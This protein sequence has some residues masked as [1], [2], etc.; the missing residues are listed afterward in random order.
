[1]GD[2]PMSLVP[3]EKSEK[4]VKVSRE[5]SP[6]IGISPNPQPSQRQRTDP[7][8]TRPIG[9]GTPKVSSKSVSLEPVD[10]MVVNTTAPMS[11][12]SD[13]PTKEGN[14][15]SGSDVPATILPGRD[16]SE[17]AVPVPISIVP[18]TPEVTMDPLEPEPEEVEM[19]EDKLQGEF[20][21]PLKDEDHTPPEDE[22]TVKKGGIE[23]DKI[24][25]NK[26]FIEHYLH[27]PYDTKSMGLTGG[28]YMD[29]ISEKFGLKKF[30]SD[31]KID[32]PDF[33]QP[34]KTSL[35]CKKANMVVN[36]E[37]LSYED[38]ERARP[39]RR[40][41]E[42]TQC[43]MTGLPINNGDGRPADGY[44]CEHYLIIGDIG[45][46]LRLALDE[47]ENILKKMVDKKKFTEFQELSKSLWSEVY[48]PSQP[49]SN[50]LKA[51]HDF[52]NLDHKDLS[53][54]VN[55]HNI[56]RMMTTLVFGYRN[57]NSHS[58]NFR[59]KFLAHI[60]GDGD[61][62]ELT[63]ADKLKREEAY[64]HS[65]IQFLFKQAEDFCELWKE[66][67][68]E[69][70]KMLINS[71]AS[72]LT[73]IR[74]L[75]MKKKEQLIKIGSKKP[76]S[77]AMKSITSFLKMKI[78]ENSANFL[79]KSLAKAM[80]VFDNFEKAAKKILEEGNVKISGSMK[81]GAKKI[82]D[83]STPAASTF[84]TI[85]EI[86]DSG[87]LEIL[88]RGEMTGDYDKLSGE[89]QTELVR[90][91]IEETNLEYKELSI[92]C[93]FDSKGILNII[94]ALIY[95]GNNPLQ[96][97]LN[98]ERT[99]HKDL[100]IELYESN[101]EL[102][103]EL[104]DNI[105]SESIYSEKPTIDFL[106]SEE[107]I[108]YNELLET[109]RSILLPTELEPEPEPEM[110]IS[111]TI[112]GKKKKTKKKRKSKSKKGKSTKKTSRKKKRK[113]TRKKKKQSDLIDKI[114]DRL[115]Y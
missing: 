33:S 78:G 50:L 60:H 112:K 104:I 7:S 84:K 27:C 115:G 98:E 80:C 59:T 90:V 94:T 71:S 63:D 113:T 88:S 79:K 37:E 67:T 45:N 43:Y 47:Y 87:I 65:R 107:M 58:I 6:G 110:E 2:K 12:G 97:R 106:M 23:R 30:K 48:K 76:S 62:D 95:E 109:A 73:T 100:L 82:S 14:T 68:K 15:Q 86:G 74:Y 56:M 85:G 105:P 4:D 55:Y 38:G 36:E 5:R 61:G 66:K 8:E 31:I 114:I 64:L 42:P 34:K 57:K 24:N 49:P 26:T 10:E 22:K 19:T 29:K 17:D 9:L 102:L 108:E 13:T 40:G 103:D 39:Y 70:T 69:G 21:L 92:D 111:E 35:E 52:I 46:T 101:E 99:A 75:H 89:V 81:G 51:E 91:A 77:T 72:V 54:S 32:R 41:G 18:G 1:M 25:S 20:L 16:P 11:I 96:C 93:E 53:V 28:N 44:H 83:F 3:M